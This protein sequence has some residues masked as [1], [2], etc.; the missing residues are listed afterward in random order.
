MRY[1]WGAP[2]NMDQGL[3]WS[4]Y[5]SYADTVKVRL[6]KITTGSVTPGSRRLA[7]NDCEELLAMKSKLT[8]AAAALLCPALFGQTDINGGRNI[9]GRW[10]AGQAAS[11]VPFKTGVVSALPHTAPLERCTSRW[12]AA[13]TGGTS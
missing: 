8:L 6:C 10:D 13:S 12:T 4:A 7:R 3:L 11:T 1:S 5:V 9:L 2:A